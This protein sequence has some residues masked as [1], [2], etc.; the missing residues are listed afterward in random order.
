[1]KTK[2]CLKEPKQVSMAGEQQGR[3]QV[4]HEEKRDTGLGSSKGGNCG[5]YAKSNE[6]SQESDMI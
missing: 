6:G 5:F 4:F 1:M 3:R 2:L